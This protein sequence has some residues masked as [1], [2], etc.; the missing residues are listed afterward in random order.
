MRA[1]GESQILKTLMI[2]N[3]DSFQPAHAYAGTRAEDQK[4]LNDFMDFGFAKPPKS[5]LDVWFPLSNP[6]TANTFY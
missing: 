2:R 6:T 5:A 1:G 4:G 3:C